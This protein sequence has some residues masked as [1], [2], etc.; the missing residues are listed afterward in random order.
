MFRILVGLLYLVEVMPAQNTYNF[1]EAGRLV[2][3][4]GYGFV[5]IDIGLTELRT[6]AEAI[7]EL[8]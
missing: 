1:V 8:Q 2:S 5:M 3:G 6:R 7:T 4:V